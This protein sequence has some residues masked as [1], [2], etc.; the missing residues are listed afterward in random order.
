MSEHSPTQTELAWAAGFFDGE[1]SIGI[2]KRTQYCGGKKYWGWRVSARLVGVHKPSIERFA[3]IVGIGTVGTMKRATR[4]GK[5]VWRWSAFDKQVPP[6]MLPLLPY[7]IVKADQVRLS[8]LF[9][10]SVGNFGSKGTPIELVA[11]QTG[12]AERMKFLKTVLN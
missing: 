2:Y 7:L 10:E 11:K 4:T 9:R 1:G 3:S 8:V 5:K 6:S 12:M